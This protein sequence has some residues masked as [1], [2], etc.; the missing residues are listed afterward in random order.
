M[1]CFRQTFLAFAS[2]AKLFCFKHWAWQMTSIGVFI[3]QHI[4]NS[5]IYVSIVAISRIQTKKICAILV[6]QLHCHILS[7]VQ[8]Y[9][10]V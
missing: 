8:L 3:V 1:L 2:N 6:Q 10:A 9:T 7:I 4:A 5:L